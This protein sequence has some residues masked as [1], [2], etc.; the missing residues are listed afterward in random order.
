M[1]PASL[2]NRLN[3]DGSEPDHLEEIE[4]RAAWRVRYERRDEPLREVTRRANGRQPKAPAPRPEDYAEEHR[5]QDSEVTTRLCRVLARMTFTLWRS[6]VVR[7]RWSRVGLMGLVDGHPV[8]DLVRVAEDA[9]TE[10]Q[11][12][13]QED[14]REPAGCRP[15]EDALS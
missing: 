6:G 8:T 13:S 3:G 4:R 14:D 11:R 7:T 5:D 12:R 9:V 10:Q 15:G 2:S 1:D